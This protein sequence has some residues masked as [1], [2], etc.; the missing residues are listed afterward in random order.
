MA[1][2]VPG[3]RESETITSFF[4]SERFAFDFAFLTIIFL[5]TSFHVLSEDDPHIFIDQ[6][7]Q[8]M[9]QVLI[10]NKD[11]FKENR[12]EYENKIKEIFE[13]MIDFKR[14]AASVMGKKYYLA[15]TLNQRNN[16]VEIFKDSLLDTYAETLAQWENQAIET[17]FPEEALSN[18]IKNIEYSICC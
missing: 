3:T 18:N 8:M 13:P 14:V 15:S 10:E 12:N 9:V 17:I 16:F 6:N 1:G 2:T 5:L 7:A 11:L 4:V